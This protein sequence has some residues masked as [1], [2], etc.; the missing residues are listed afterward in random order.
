MT[1]NNNQCTPV[2]I[3]ASEWAAVCAFRS[4]PEYLQD[5]ILFLLRMKA[6]DLKQLPAAPEESSSEY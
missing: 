2:K 3:T 5:T 4:V 1:A 6:G